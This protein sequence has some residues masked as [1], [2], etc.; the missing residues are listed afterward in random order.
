[1]S[2]KNIIIGIA[3]IILTISV[4]VY[5]VGILYDRPDYSDFCSEGIRSPKIAGEDVVCPEVCVEMYKI[6]EGECVL[7]DCGSGC[8]A[9][10]ISTFDTLAQCEIVLAGENCEDEYDEALENYS[11]N[12]FLIALPLGILIIALGALAFGLEAVG[13]GIMGGGVGIILWGVMGFWQFA[14]D[15]LKFFLSLAGLIIVVWLA[16]YFNKRLEK[17]S[18]KKKK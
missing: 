1:M 18:K 4:A 9:N 8:G 10:G 16:Y 17:K 14:D 6:E 3:I 7:D 12:I 11:R 2:L 13:A 5:G 15:W